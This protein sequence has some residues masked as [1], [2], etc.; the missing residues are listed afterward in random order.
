[1]TPNPG[2]PDF[3][4]KTLV[5][6]PSGGG[7][8]RVLVRAAMVADAHRSHTPG[9]ILMSR[10]DGR[11]RI[12]EVGDQTEIRIPEDVEILDLPDRVIIPAL[13]N[14][15]TH[16]DLTHIG[17]IAHDPEEGFVSWVDIIR[18][19]RLIDPDEIA[20][21]VRDGIG[22]SIRGGTIAVGDIAGAPRTEL[23]FAPALELAR[24]PL[25]GVSFL[26]FFGIGKSCASAIERI[27]RFI[28]EEYDDLVESMSNPNVR[29]GLSPHAT[30]TVD[31][32]VYRF[33]SRAAAARGIPLTTH[34]A[35][36]LEEREFI[37]NGTGTQRGLLDKVGVWDD[38]IL[39]RVGHGAH[40]IEHL[41][42]VLE[43]APY[44]C[45]HVNDAPERFFGVLR[46]TG[47]SV[48]FC[49]RAHS[50]F[51]HPAKIGRHPYRA[52]LDSGI[53]VCLGTDSIVNLDTHD[54]IG[55]L[56]DIRHLA[57]HD[58]CSSQLLL[59]M[60]TING[61][62]AL[63]LNTSGFELVRGNTPLGLLALPID[64]GV[65]DPWTGAIARDEAP[66]WAVFQP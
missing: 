58:G 27:T 24:S 21:A 10:H 52:M 47:C 37:A 50:Y 31:V 8:E 60:G 34:L 7:S 53:N 20:R 6:P 36:T 15:H 35:E 66:E 62:K 33:I 59:A 40:P 17:P 22:C 19:G 41:A 51:G 45:A 14:A 26:E 18:A 29:L 61:A 54:R 38:S 43:L 64:P 13:V 4:P 3:V 42:P 25:H 16:L 46:E 23:T 55:V 12:E 65:P 32:D 63:G 39:D 2:Q 49:A 44:L 1:M 57:R 56:D 11:W 30:N 28:A 48:A 9:A 5:N